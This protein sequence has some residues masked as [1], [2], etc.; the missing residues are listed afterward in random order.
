MNEGNYTL[1][2]KLHKTKEG[3]WCEVDPIPWDYAEGFGK[4]PE[5]AMIEFIEIMKEKNPSDRG[6]DGKLQGLLSCTQEG[7]KENFFYE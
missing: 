4:T 3:W 5:D 6:E 1:E 7:F 2:L